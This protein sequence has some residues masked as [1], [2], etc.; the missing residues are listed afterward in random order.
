MRFFKVKKKPSK[1]FSTLT[2]ELEEKKAAAVEELREKHKAVTAWAKK[3][4]IKPQE[5]ASK[6]ARGLVAGVASGAIVLSV[7]ASPD[8]EISSKQ[9]QNQK[10]INRDISD[11]GMKA[12]VKGREDVTR[13]VQAALI[14]VS[15]HDEKT[16]EQRLSKV[17]RIPVKAQLEGTRLNTTYG[18]MGYES[19][20]SR[21]PG[22]N[23]YTHFGSDTEFK[24]FAKAG[25]AGGPGAWGYIAPSREKLRP[26]DIEREKYYLVAQTL[27]SPNWG[28]PAVKNWFRHRKMVVVNP[29]NGGVVVGVL[30]DAGPES[31]TGRSFG[32][33]PE[34]V[35]E[36]DLVLTG[37]SVLMYFVD[38]PTDQIPLGRYGR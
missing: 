23:L 16:I 14:G 5:V 6:S 30:E 15:L 32:G 34:V 21:Y 27:L 1:H 36:L 22:D 31:T 17:L 7:G 38:D 19:H 24:K 28:T 37:S 20:L 13:Q 9:A 29:A 26:K 18:I 2:K 35:E 8:G 25:M 12:A 10:E 33:S 11:T 3:K 4:G